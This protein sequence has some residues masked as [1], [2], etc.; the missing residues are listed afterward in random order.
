MYIAGRWLRSE[1]L[2]RFHITIL[3]KSILWSTY[4]LSMKRMRINSA[5][6]DMRTRLGARTDSHIKGFNNLS[7]DIRPTII[8]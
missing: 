5:K 1:R 7:R 3:H 4:S 6:P 2:L 8:K